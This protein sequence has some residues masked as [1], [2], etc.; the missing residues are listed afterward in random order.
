[1]Q[2]GDNDI[3]PLAIRLLQKRELLERGDP[4]YTSIK[5]ALFIDGGGMRGVYGGG[6]VIALEKL[7]LTDV[8][9]YV[10][11]VSAGAA[12]CAYFLSGQAELGNS[13]YYKEL[14][15]KRF[16]NP[17]RF[18]RILDIDYLD[19]AFRHIKALDSEKIKSSRS[20]FFIGVTNAD[21]GAC[22]FL[23]MQ[24]PS[25][26]IITAI[27]ASTA[28]PIVYHKDVTINGVP[29]SDGTTACGI[30]VEHL[31]EDLGCNTLLFVINRH[32][33]DKPS[34][35]SWYERALMGA[36]P[37]RYSPQFRSAY[38]NRR[39]AYNRSLAIV[40]GDVQT[41]GG[42]TLGVLSPKSMSVTNLTTNSTKLKH[43]SDVATAQTLELF[44]AAEVKYREQNK[45]SAIV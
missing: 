12:N 29:Y 2:D 33:I 31:L 32:L 4:A 20:R 27:R 38:L 41:N 26:D 3:T 16:I 5:T 8:F 42:V 9:D 21:T 15:H 30:P 7:G 19:E 39:T 14:A 40:R 45:T 17:I 28:L 18:W 10:V 34:K 44:H 11:G 43:L 24:D 13:L 37:S 25:I 6:V 35:A 1:M 22:E 36:L 23:D